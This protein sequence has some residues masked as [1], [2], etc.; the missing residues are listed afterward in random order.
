[1]PRGNP[2]QGESRTFR[3]PPTLFPVAQGVNTDSD[4]LCELRLGEADEI[5]QR[6]N[7]ST[8]FE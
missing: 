6:R 8:G 3:S 5:T 1:M 4:C 2:Q 7:V